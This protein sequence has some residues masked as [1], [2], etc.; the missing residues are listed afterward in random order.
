LSRAASEDARTAVEQ[1]V[2]RINDTA[3]FFVLIGIV[4]LLVSAAMAALL[5]RVLAEPLQEITNAATSI[6]AGDLDVRMPVLE[7]RDEVGLLAQAF[8]RMVHSLQTMAQA[9]EK[10]AGGDLTVTL[11]PQSAKDVLGLSFGVMTENLRG[12]AQEMKEGTTVLHT[13]SAEILKGITQLT[14]DLAGME[15]ATVE[16]DTIIQQAGQAMLPANQTQDWVRRAEAAFARI[17]Q[18]SVNGSARASQARAT[19]QNLEELGT[20]LGFVVGKLKV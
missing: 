9:T 8:A 5:S 13:L 11:K 18:A 7:R 4:V 16:A 17:K 1:S 19:A 3:L 20:R 15:T 10:I 12:L 14:S 2:Q 6:A